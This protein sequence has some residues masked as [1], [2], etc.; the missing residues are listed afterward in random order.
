MDEQLALFVI[1]KRRPKFRRKLNYQTW[2]YNHHHSTRRYEIFRLEYFI[3]F[4]VQNFVVNAFPSLLIETSPS[5]F[6]L[7]GL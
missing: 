1:L 7:E 6:G 5:G 3:F 2:G 4:L